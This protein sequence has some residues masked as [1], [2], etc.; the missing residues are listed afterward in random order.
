MKK[1]MLIFLI[2]AII[3]GIM[4][5]YDVYR[6]KQFMLH[7]VSTSPQPAVADGATPFFLDVQ[8]LY[9]DKMPVKGHDIYAL[10]MNGGSFERY[11]LRT[12]ENGMVNF[13]YYPYAS[14]FLQKAEDV[15]IQFM[16][17]SNSVFIIV[18]AKSATKIRLVDPVESDSSNQRSLDDLLGG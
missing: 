16:D 9:K 3:F 15:E 2:I 18:N 6:S 14:S 1:K 10:S 11:R 5:L 7:V 4:A 17:Q 12:D 8:L 13:K